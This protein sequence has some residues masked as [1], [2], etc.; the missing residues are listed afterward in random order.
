MNQNVNPYQELPEINSN[1]N[2]PGVVDPSNVISIPAP[3]DSVKPK[4]KLPLKSLLI[5]FIIGCLFI[6]VIMFYLFFSGKV[7]FSNDV[8]E[9]SEQEIIEL[10]KKYESSNKFVPF[11]LDKCINS[12][13]DDN[14]YYR[15]ATF[16]ENIN[17]SVVDNEIVFTLTREQE[18]KLANNLDDSEPIYK[19]TGFDKEIAEIYIG[20]F[21]DTLD[22]LSLFVITKDGS[23][24]YSNLYNGFKNSKDKE[25]NNLELV[26][27]TKGITKLLNARSYNGEET[28]FTMLGVLKD[29]SYYDMNEFINR[30]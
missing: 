6:L 1:N 28:T 13:I 11:K 12:T 7:L 29:G 25:F 2:Q 4:K 19:I 18:A 30:G 22:L 10:E 5:G 14:H 24:Y 3:E 21:G 27:D 20:G 23:L 15:L 17:T 9:K 8:L 16:T 26:K